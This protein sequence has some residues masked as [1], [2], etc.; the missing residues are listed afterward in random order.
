EVNGFEV[1][2]TAELIGNPLARFARVIE[3][4]HRSDGVYAQA[5]NVEA[6]APEER[7]GEEEIDDFVAAIIEDQG[8][9]V[10][11]G[12]FAWILVLEEGGAVEASQRP[13]V[14]WE[15]S[16]HP[17]HYHTQARFVEGVDQKLEILRR[18]VAA[19][20]RIKAGHLIA[21]RRIK[22]MFGHGHEFDV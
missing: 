10:L 18:A 17:V 2:A 11:V 3:I 15:V 14:A 6:L 5:V 7:V 20:G 19:G 21:P 16:G 22:R 9:P 13:V 4:K 8:A 12:A 1:L